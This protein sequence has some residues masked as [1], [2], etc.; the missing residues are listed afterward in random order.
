PGP[1][2]LVFG[3]M[4]DK[5]VDAVAQILF[6]LFESVIATE[7]Y[8]PRSVAGADLAAIGRE[9][10]V[11]VEAEPSPARAFERAL[12]SSERSVF[13]GGS[14]YLAGAGIEFFD[15]QRDRRGKQKK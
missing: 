5:N 10:G 13:V 4:R 6:P 9:I 1:R 15:A 2:L 7:P 14:L 11:R 8:P 3:I 12:R